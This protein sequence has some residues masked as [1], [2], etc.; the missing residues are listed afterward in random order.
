MWDLLLNPA[1]GETAPKG[2]HEQLY[3]VPTEVTD[4]LQELNVLR[5]QIRD[6]TA[7]VDAL[8][9]QLDT[10]RDQ[11]SQ[12]REQLPERLG[13]RLEELESAPAKEEPAQKEEPKPEP[14]K[15]PARRTRSSSRTQK[16][17]PGES[18]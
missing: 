14:P 2:L 9:A 13:S 6:L 1:P 11:V 12:V 4:S 17:K 10:A 15:P 16:P 5:A 8:H 18:S 7:T 3:T